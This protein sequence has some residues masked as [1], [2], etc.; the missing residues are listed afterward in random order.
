MNWQIKELETRSIVSSSDAHSGPKLGREATVFVENSQ[1][2]LPAG[3]RNPQFSYQDII[4]AIKQI[5]QGKLKI[6]YTIEFFPEEGKYHWSGHRACNIRYTPK[7]VKEKGVICPKCKRPLTIGVENR[8]VDLSEK[9]F[10][11]NDLLFIKNKSG[12]TFVYDKEKKRRPFVSLIPLME[13]LLE[14]NNNSPTKAAA[15]Y[16]RLVTNFA[17]E[18]DIILRKSYDE[19]ERFGSQK[20]RSAIEIIRNRQVFVDPGYDG[21]FGRVKIFN[22]KNNQENEKQ[23]N[24]SQPSLF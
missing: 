2:D 12:M 15:E 22:E 3:G 23:E 14:T 10:D 24:G 16:E 8:V 6:G 20:L 7:E 17:P 19:I 9:I 4:E 11:K 5:P 13:I 1:S 21:V 18:F